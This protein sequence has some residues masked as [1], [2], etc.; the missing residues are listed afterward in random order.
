MSKVFFHGELL[1]CFWNVRK[2]EL[3]GSEELDFNEGFAEN[4]WREF[5]GEEEEEEVG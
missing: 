1:I 2:F 5:E 3:V 4:I